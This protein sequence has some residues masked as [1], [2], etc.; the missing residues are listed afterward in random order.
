VAQ[1]RLTLATGGDVYMEVEDSAD[2]LHRLFNGHPPFSKAW[3]EVEK[4][5]LIRRDTIVAA[6]DHS[7]PD[8]RL[9]RS[10]DEQFGT[11]VGT[12]LSES[13]HT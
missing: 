6:R 13:Q 10:A 9:S 8:D 2:A 12:D 3:V 1:L 5:T 11:G 7:Q 4:G